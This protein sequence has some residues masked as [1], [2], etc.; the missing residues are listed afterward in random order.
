[1]IGKTLGSRYEIDKLI[2]E[3]GMAQVYRARD[4]LLNRTVA[5]KILR[6]Q[7]GGDE[8]FI[9]RFQEIFVP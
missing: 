9:A 3:G 6:S 8:D 7:F 4:L 2:G 5:V 1:M